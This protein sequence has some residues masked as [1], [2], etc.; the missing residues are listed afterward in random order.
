MSYSFQPHASDCAVTAEPDA[1]TRSGSWLGD[2]VALDARTLA[3]FRVLLTLGLLIDFGHAALDYHDL[4]SD[5]GV[6]P[7]AAVLA[8]WPS[9]VSNSIYLAAGADWLGYGLLALHGLAI[10]SLM[11]GYRC[12]LATLACLIFTASLQ[13]RDYLTNQASDDLFRL[14][15]FWALFVPV[16]ARWSVDA[17]LNETR[18]PQRI[19]SI[20][21][22]GLQAQ[23][24]CVYL[25]GALL[26]FHGAPW[27]DGQAVAMAVSD[28]TYGSIIGRML[29]PWH[30]LLTM[31][32][33]G[34]ETIEFLMPWLMWF[35]IGNFAIRSAALVLLVAMHIGF[36][37]L[38][39]VGIF[40]LA[41]IGSLCLFITARHWDLL[42]ARLRPAAQVSRIFYDGGCGF[43]RKTCLLLRAFCLDHRVPIL[44]ADQDP[45]ALE[46]LRRHNSWVVYD[47]AGAPHVRW[48]AVCQVAQAS[49]LFGPFGRIGRWPMAAAMGEAVY[50][51]IAAN[52]PAFGRIT[53]R[54]LPY[55]EDRGQ[56]G[57]IGRLVAWAALV[58]ILVYNVAQIPGHETVAPPWLKKFVIDSRLEQK[59]TM[60][61]PVPQSLT[62][63]S[64]VR[65]TAVD[66]QVY[67][68]ASGMRKPYSEALPAHGQVYPRDTRWKKYLDYLYTKAGAPFRL[69]YAQFLCR[70][71]NAQAAPAQ[72][73]RTLNFR[74]FI[75][76]P[77]VPR[78]PPRQ[79]IDL[80]DYACTR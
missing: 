25:F 24:M 3:L 34:V 29:L 76:H 58:A 23:A 40:P 36:F 7:R 21:A 69:Y 8:F 20:G 53:A 15:L 47:G 14:L 57:W 67:D 45:A 30:G 71:L 56:L 46:L 43:C 13:T 62:Q 72:Q 61:A 37:A 26:K 66:G 78:P 41:S 65:G 39:H 52:R 68:V 55:H 77:F 16:G 80:G 19:C 70:T 22:V 6:M 4:F 27:I 28:G 79:I 59:W 38:L 12:R 35:P 2:L 49:P 1:G 63:W 51:F 64:V 33:Y 60:F 74:L 5:Q 31:V 9:A 32:T 50:G 11:I 10:I 17:A 44:P 42:A 48:D 73:I 54:L 18:I 75:E